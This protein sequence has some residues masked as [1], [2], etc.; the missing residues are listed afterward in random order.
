MTEKKI[1]NQQADF[2]KATKEFDDIFAAKIHQNPYI[3]VY[4]FNHILNIFVVAGVISEEG[5][6]NIK[7]TFKREVDKRMDRK[8]NTPGTIN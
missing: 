2:E 3:L 6:E 5:V 8:N 1:E 4:L 7:D